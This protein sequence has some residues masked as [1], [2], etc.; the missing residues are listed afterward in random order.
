MT[1]SFVAKNEQVAS[2]DAGIVGPCVCVLALSLVN[3][4]VWSVSTCS[5]PKHWSKKKVVLSSGIE[6]GK[7]ANNKVTV[8]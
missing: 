2:V 1:I 8:Y 6:I 4:S 7:A 3:N 5:S